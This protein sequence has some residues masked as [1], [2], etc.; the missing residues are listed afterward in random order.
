MVLQ[1]Q[2]QLEML[3][4][5]VFTDFRHEMSAYFSKFCRQNHMRK[6][7]TLTSAPGL[8]RF[9]TLTPV[10]GGLLIPIFAEHSSQPFPGNVVP[11][12][13]PARCYW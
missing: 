10:L 4:I 9:Q 2:D 5:G 12:L 13:I 11:P 7:I 1:Y 6:R 3:Q 8:H